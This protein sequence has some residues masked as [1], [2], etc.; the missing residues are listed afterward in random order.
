MPN[1]KQ[2]NI[3]LKKTLLLLSFLAFFSFIQVSSAADVKLA[4]DA[5]TEP[6][7][8]GYKVYYGTAPRTYGTP[9]S[10]GNVTTHTVAGLAPGRT[11]FFAVTAV[12]GS[13]QESSY[14]EEAAAV[15]QSLKTGWNLIAAPALTASS[16]ILDFLAPLAGLYEMVYAYIGSD[17]VDPWKIFNPTAPSYVNDLQS[18]DSSMGIWIKMK[19]NAEFLLPGKF[20][21]S[22]TVPLFTGWNLV[23]YRGNRSSPIGEALSSI[24]GKFE[25]VMTHKAEDMSDPWKIY[26]PLAPSYVNDLSVMEP[27]LGYWIRVKE[28]C[29]LIVNN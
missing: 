12:N 28:N 26:D 20:P 17:S 14:S 3:A 27:G 21:S 22:S 9:L 6:D 8:T 24:S 11:Y 2:R 15:I 4:W 7:L 10:P 25:R 16:S 1:M 13:N 5:N 23:S 29:S 18:V 19:Q